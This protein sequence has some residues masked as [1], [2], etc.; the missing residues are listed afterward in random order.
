MVIDDDLRKNVSNVGRWLK[1]ELKT[2]IMFSGK[3]GNGKTTM[4]KMLQKAVPMLTQNRYYV[5]FVSA[6]DL[7]DMAQNAE[8]DYR[9]LKAAQILAIDDVGAEPSVV[10]RYGNELS[11]TT[12]IIYYRYDNRMPTI[13]S[14]NLRKSD[15]ENVYGE[16]I[17]DRVNGFFTN[18][19][20][21][22]T[23]YRK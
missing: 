15:I 16:R 11:P 10:K 23:S 18:L 4:V 22:Q 1:G 19:V 5:S 13:I 14:T 12:D 3:C 21:K 2:S 17:S 6:M 7:V 8:R 20:F 9:R